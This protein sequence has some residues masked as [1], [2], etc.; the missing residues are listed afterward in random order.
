MKHTFIFL[1]ACLLSISASAATFDSSKTY[2]IKNVVC[3]LYLSLQ[4]SYKEDAAVNATPLVKEPVYFTLT[5]SADGK[6]YAIGTADG[7]M[8]FSS[9]SNLSGWNTGYSTKA[10]YNWEI[11]TTAVEGV[12]VITSS[13]GALKYDGTN[14]FAYTDGKAGSDG[15]TWIIEE[16]SATPG[17][18]KGIPGIDYPVANLRGDMD[19]DG[20]LT[21][22]DVAT[23]VEIILTNEEPLFGMADYKDPVDPIDPVDPVDPVNPGVDGQFPVPDGSPEWY[24]TDKAKNLG[25]LLQKI[26]PSL[27]LSRSMFSLTDAQFATI[28]TA[29]DAACKNCTTDADKISTLNDWVHSYITYDNN[30]SGNDPWTAFQTKKGVCQGYSNLLKVAL[31]T[32]NIPS[33]GV[34]GYY[35]NYGHAWTYAYDGKVWYVCDPT[36]A[37]GKKLMTNYSGYSHLMPDM[38][39]IDLFEDDNCVY[40]YYEGY[41]NVCKVK[42]AAANFTVPYGKN[43][44][45]VCSFN[46]S[47]AIPSSVRNIYIG[48]NVKSLGEGIVGL[49]SYPS[50]D[51]MCYVQEGNP[52]F[53]SYEGVVYKRDLYNSAYDSVFYI[54][55]KMKTLRLRP[56]E[57]ADKNV[58]TRLDNVETIIFAEGTKELESYAVEYCPNLLTVYVPKDCT[59]RE[60]A[61]DSKTCPK[62][63]IV[64]GLPE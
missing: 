12:Y 20:L 29:A 6:S 9:T 23:I 46:P 62:A 4:S 57:K 19:G 5:P 26:D 54:P 39:D 56:M 48:Y 47:T 28:K 63:K 61:V 3:N 52:Q 59:V 18:E 17:P 27:A 11:N 49:R 60:N 31:L 7:Y 22:A 38:A 35:S 36:N 25:G 10:A 45:R 34:N 30:N 50:N 64:Y 55:T 42:S 2:S 33:I 41:L 13:K 58:V 37:T 1:V 8:T 53:F 24:L 51:E 32:Q 44:F 16:Q 15:T 40:N 14:N 21:M 43:G